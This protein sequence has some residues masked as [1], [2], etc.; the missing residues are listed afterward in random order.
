MTREPRDSAVDLP[1]LPSVHALEVVQGYTL[2]RL[3]AEG[4]IARVYQ[5]ASER[6]GGVVVVKVVQPALAGDRAAK[7]RLLRENRL[8]A[9]LRNH[10]HVVRVLDVGEG[11]AG[12][13]VVQEQVE[14]ETLRAR[15]VRAGRLGGLDAL[16]AVRDAARGLD[17]AAAIGVAH[18]DVKP[19]NLFCGPDGVVKVADFG[20]AAPLSLV[21]GPAGVF[22][23]PAFLAPELVRGAPP[24]VRSDVYALGATLWQLLT[25]RP[26]FEGTSADVLAAHTRKPIPSIA[27]QVPDAGIVVVD[28][29]YRFLQKEPARRPQSW[30]ETIAILDAGIE[31]TRRGTTNAPA[32]AGP[33]ASEPQWPT[34]ASGAAVELPPLPPPPSSSPLM[35]SSSSRPPSAARPPT[36]PFE[37]PS[38]E[39]EPYLAQPTG[40]MGT[41]KQMGVVE[42]VQMLEIGKKSAR[43]DFQGV[44]GW[45]G[46]LYVHDGQL[47][48]CTFDA[49]TG[50]HAVVA[51]CRKKE[52]FFRIHYEKERCEK[53]VTRPTT[54]VLLE[55]MR[56]IDET[57]AE[58]PAPPPPAPSMPPPPARDATVRASP[59]PALSQPPTRSPTRP[60]T[61]PSLARPDADDPTVS[62]D[63]RPVSGLGDGI[64]FTPARGA[65]DDPTLPEV[66][67]VHVHSVTDVRDAPDQPPAL[68]LGEE[69]F[70]DKARSSASAAAG[71]AV[72]A[73]A[74]V[75]KNVAARVAFSAPR[76]WA[77]SNRALAPLSQALARLHP[78]LGAAPP[79]ALV[80]GALALTLTLV[81]VVVALV[82]GGGSGPSYA[83][84]VA[85]LRS[86]NAHEVARELAA[87]APVERSAEQELAL[88]HALV[89]VGDDAGALAAY[90]E[91][92]PAGVTD[93]LVQGW[94]LS[95]LD[96][97]QPDD[98]LD[99]LVLWPEDDIEDALAPLTLSVSPLVRQNAV[100]VLAERSALALVD[101]G[102]M[103]TMD[104][105]D[106]DGCGERRAA[107]TILRAAGKTTAALAAI[108]NVGRKNADCFRPD[109]LARAYKAVL[110][111]T[112]K[113]AKER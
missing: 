48:R 10:P 96:A 11:G 56:T 105:V 74:D 39:A 52:G 24:D 7:D 13:Y 95:R 1:L 71:S 59:V 26:L 94:L 27:T 83:A 57:G 69:L 58:A 32:G 51:L 66:R 76:V 40:V 91:A 22:G 49:L 98:E 9:G 28:I 53:N 44:E 99:L 60:P 113:P 78:A 34:R 75:A 41:L 62:T 65:V 50:E 16:T 100:G 101:L 3:V 89:V 70:G 29:L 97:S 68:G 42:I 20:F 106:A 79:A 88:G 67:Q 6:H 12:P 77:T 47:V 45:V 19:S 31:R 102:S 5:C 85:E 14:G 4:T 38:T 108:D 36:S 55:A 110:G 46:Q 2:V 15:L 109:E 73:I 30:A 54:L 21:G 112:P 86:G 43:L 18:R 93:A 107:L 25:A 8:V 72:R 103:A 63:P 35:A 61:R 87:M 111:R 90:H 92:I 82:S 64:G 17:A 37:Q 81:I 80:A 23:T 33:S 84:A 104:L